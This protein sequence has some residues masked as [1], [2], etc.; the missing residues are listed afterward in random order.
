MAPAFSIG[1]A[2]ALAVP[3]ATVSRHPGETIVVVACMT[4]AFAMFAAGRFAATR[5]ASSG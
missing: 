3:Y 5:A 1:A 2:L 4:L